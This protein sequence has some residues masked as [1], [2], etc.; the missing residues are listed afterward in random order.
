V[1]GAHAAGFPPLGSGLRWLS[2]AF[3]VLAVF[4]FVGAI[5]GMIVIAASTTSSPSELEM[6]WMVALGF[7][8]L[9]FIGHLVIGPIWMHRAWSWLPPDQRYT[10]HWKSWIEPPQ[11]A[12][13]LVIPYFQYYWMFVISCGLCDA[14]D[15]LRERY[16]TT[17]LAPK[18]L[19]ITAGVCTLLIPMPVGAL[20][21]I[22]Y[23][24]K[25]EA[26]TEEMAR[27]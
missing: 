18:T 25:V 24:A 19:A 14:L 12:W 17:D 4:M 16:P 15:R 5:A 2:T 13:F 23:M 8:Y 7:A 9:F 10:K 27:G 22:L 21:W 3:V 26:M 6:L 20:L 1:N 11:A